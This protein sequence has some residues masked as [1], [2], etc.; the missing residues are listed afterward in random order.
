MNPDFS[1]LVERYVKGPD[2]VEGLAMAEGM[3]NEVFERAGV[4]PPRRIVLRFA[5]DDTVEIGFADQ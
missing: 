4:K 1:R 5:D 3:I 2:D